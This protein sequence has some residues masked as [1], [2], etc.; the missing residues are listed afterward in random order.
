MRPLLP[1]LVALLLLAFAA[2]VFAQPTED[3]DAIF[4]EVDRR[5][6]LLDSEAS[7]VRME[8]VDP[9]GRT[10]TRTME[11]RTKVGGDDL[12]KSIVVFTEPADIRGLGLL[13]VET[14]GGDDQRL[15]LPALGRV[16]RV[17][18]GERGE[19]FAGS[20]FTYED[21]GTRDPDDWTATLAE[22]TDAAFVLETRAKDPSSTTH[23]KLRLTI[24]RARY[25][26]LRAA[27]YTEDD[28]LAKV[29]VAEDFEEVG[30]ET[31]RAG[32]LTMEDVQDDRRTVLTY[33]E[34]EAGASIPDRV[35][36]ERTLQRGLR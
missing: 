26:I 24:D 4:E 5:Q 11:L 28:T 33:V 7:T 27:Y 30:P 32:T 20:D 18:G 16:Q 35:F 14:D 17:A 15:Y 10:R 19:R 2:P 22:T 8:I 9:R 23:P 12:T 34:R 25:V 31:F 13:T 21:L 6:R 29:L 1:L 36:S 3:A